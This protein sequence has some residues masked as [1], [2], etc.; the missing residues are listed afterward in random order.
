MPVKVMLD[1]RSA[2][3]CVPVT[4]K[5]TMPVLEPA[6]KLPLEIGRSRTRGRSG[7]LLGERDQRRGVG[8]ERVHHPVSSGFWEPP[9]LK[10][11]CGAPGT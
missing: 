9:P 6:L 2:S 4:S 1:P 11:T 8:G 5:T 3:N 7:E 10:F